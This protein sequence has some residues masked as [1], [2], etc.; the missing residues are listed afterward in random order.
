[1]RYALLTVFIVVVLLPTQG[2]GQ[3]TGYYAPEYQ[4]LTRTEVDSIAASIFDARIWN[5]T[6]DDSNLVPLDVYGYMLDVLPEFVWTKETVTLEEL[7]R[8]Q[9]V[10]SILWFVLR[11]N[12]TFGAYSWSRMKGIGYWDATVVND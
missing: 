7:I 12:S 5:A 8:D 10:C 6:C 4:A 9:N 11:K 1:M 3:P 2:I